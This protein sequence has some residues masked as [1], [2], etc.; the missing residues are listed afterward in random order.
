VDYTP[1]LVKVSDPHHRLSVGSGGPDAEN[2][3]PLCRLHHDEVGTLGIANFEMKYNLSLKALAIHIYK[4]YRDSCLGTDRSKL[5]YADH[6]QIL[7]RI[8]A[9]R[10]ASLEIGHLLARFRDEMID[11]KHKWHMLGF[12][13]FASYVGAPVQSGGLALSQ[14]TAYRCLYFSEAADTASQEPVWRSWDQPKPKRS[15]PC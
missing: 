3:V 8:E 10:E 1:E 2:L 9:L 12:D 13:T 7:S 6:Q 11:G 14:R 4:R 15:S 5:A